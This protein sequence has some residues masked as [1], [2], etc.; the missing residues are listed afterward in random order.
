M[1]TAVKRTISLPED[2]ARETEEI[3]RAEGKSFSAIVQEALRVARAQRTRSEL[4]DLQAF[5]TRKA[6]DVGIVSEADLD[7]YLAD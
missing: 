3:A 4:R 2:L 7:R 6:R 1:G 5:W